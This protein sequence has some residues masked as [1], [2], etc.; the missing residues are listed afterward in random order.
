MGNPRLGKTIAMG[1]CRRKWPF[2]RLARRKGRDVGLGKN[3][4]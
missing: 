2:P 4:Q 3:L 1:R